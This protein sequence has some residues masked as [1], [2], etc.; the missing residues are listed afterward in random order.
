MGRLTSKS[1]KSY[2]IEP[3]VQLAVLFTKW[4]QGYV[5]KSLD[6]NLQLVWREHVIYYI[7]S[8]TG[9]SRL[10]RVRKKC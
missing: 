5:E 9:W 1:Y 6:K 10:L 4:L 8:A 2:D 3:S 7:E